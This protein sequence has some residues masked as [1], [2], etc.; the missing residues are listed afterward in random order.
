MF[1]KEEKQSKQGFPSGCHHLVLHALYES[2]QCAVV[3]AKTKGFMII[4]FFSRHIFME[5]IQD[6]G[7]QVFSW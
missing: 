1:F 5:L 4:I 2:G 3:T 6:P 7:D